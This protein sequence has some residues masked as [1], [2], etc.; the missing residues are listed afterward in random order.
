MRIVDNKP[1]LYAIFLFF[2]FAFT[3]FAARLI[4]LQFIKYSSFR[5]KATGQ[6]TFLLTLEP[7]RGG[8]FDRKMRNLACNLKVDSLYAIPTHIT[9]KSETAS[10]LAQILNL[11]EEK[12][13]ERLSRQKAF[14]WIKRKVSREEAEE[15]AALKI[16][17]IGSIEESKR[18][19]PNGDLASHIL[20]FTDIDNKGLE[21]IELFYDQYL[22]GEVGWKEIK[23]DAKGRELASET[24]K[25]LPPSNGYD[26]VLAVDE[27]IQHVTEKALDRVCRKYNAKAATAVVMD[28]N[29]GYILALTNRPTYDPGNITGSIPDSRRNRAITDCFEPGSSFKIVTASAALDSAIVDM[30]MVFFC[31]NGSWNVRGHL[32]HDHKPHGDLTFKQVME[33]SSN[34]GTV[35]VA[36]LLD[37]KNLYK[38]IRKFGF[39]VPTRLDLPGE[40]AGILRPQSRW[41]KF[42]ISSIPMGQE[43]G[44][45]AL[46]MA[47]ALSVIANGGCYLEP[48]IVGEIRDRM[49]HAVRSF[50]P[51]SARRVISEQ[52]AAKMKEILKGVVEN[53]TGKCARLDGY[54]S[55]GKTGTAQ[56]VE[57]SGGYSH[58]KFISSFIGFAPVE[59]PKIVVCVFVDEPRPVYYGGTVAAPAFKEIAEATLKYMELE[60][61]G[62]VEVRR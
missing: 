2:V 21:G 20:G 31:E 33:K 53:G 7:E 23:R 52:A 38:Y 51:A 61:E 39:G 58:S 24:T 27:I 16:R 35:K 1:R 44:V 15:V 36:L 40:V 46:Q 49:G 17:G 41:S 28:P 6:Y 57:P 19:Y 14:V 43:V 54:T 13:L 5:E 25:S 47:C 4:Y 26:I 18:L 42:S 11:D 45:T 30:D 29:T 60:K 9:E 34:I 10:K 37:E 62:I 12:L 22:K 8:I 48:M 55:A 59:E 50:K 3:V 32:L 56:K